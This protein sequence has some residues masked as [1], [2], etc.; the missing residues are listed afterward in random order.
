M[1]LGIPRDIENYTEVE[2][3]GIEVYLPRDFY[4]PHDL[5]IDVRTFLW[6]KSLFI[7][8]WKII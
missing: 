5:V 8:G 4:T 6:F 7:D 1:R 2:I 3:D